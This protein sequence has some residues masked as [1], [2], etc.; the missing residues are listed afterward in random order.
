[1]ENVSILGIIIIIIIIIMCLNSW[2]VASLTLIKVNLSLYRTGKALRVR[3][4]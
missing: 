4:G 2:S 1:M 3:R